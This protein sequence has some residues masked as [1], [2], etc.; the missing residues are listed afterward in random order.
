MQVANTS[1][2]KTNIATKANALLKRNRSG[3]A[4]FP[5]LTTIA[6]RSISGQIK[7]RIASS[8]GFLGMADELVT[9]HAK[10]E[11]IYLLATTA[12]FWLQLSMRVMLLVRYYQVRMVTLDGTELRTGGSLCWWCQSSK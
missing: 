11:A 2:L 3:R 12:I 7:M 6:A 1:L 10:H 5:S 9:L 8:P 4:T